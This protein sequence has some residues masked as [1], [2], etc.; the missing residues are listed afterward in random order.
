MPQFPAN[1]LAKIFL[2]AYSDILENLRI[3]L[4]RYHTTMRISIIG[5]AGSGK[6]TLARQLSEKLNVPHIHLDRFWFEAGGNEIW[7]RDD[8]AG[9]ERVRAVV[10]EKV[11]G[12]IAQESWVS[13]G[14]F[15]RYQDEISERADQIVFI[16]L[17]LYMRWW[18][19]LVRMM[20]RSKRHAEVSLWDDIHFFWE[21]VQKTRKNAPRIKLIIEKFKDKVVIVHSRKDIK[22]YI[23]LVA[24]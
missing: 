24:R 16:D 22:R 15:S 1:I 4:L 6:S 18:N 3:D 20:H 8:Q 10:G 13:D 7:K 14:L 11:Q 5:L 23:N 9:K 17:P 12:A 21:M 2:K 19:H